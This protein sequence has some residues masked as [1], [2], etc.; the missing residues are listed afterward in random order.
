M[1]V[2]IASLLKDS[3]DVKLAMACDQT[4]IQQ[5]A[6]AIEKIKDSLANGGTLFTCGNGGS[7]CD[8]MHFTEELVAR[9]KRER[10]GLRAQHLLDPGTI[11]CWANDYSFDAV[12]ARQVETF[13]SAKD[14]LVAISTSGNSPSILNAI[15]TA[16]KLGC[17][18]IGLLGKGGGKA[19]AL[20]NLPI[21]VPNDETE[22]IQE[23]HI[24][25]IHIIC[26]ALEA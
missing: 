7:A 25:L 6:S 9:F 18:T 13:C 3:A 26:E 14:I 15:E 8:A 21:I 23:A 10:K 2:D 20:C 1:K 16:K 12:F 17:F 11:T 24:T 19:K 4:L 5:T 22:R